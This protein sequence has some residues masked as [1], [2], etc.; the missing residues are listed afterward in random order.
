MCCFSKQLWFCACAV[1]Y[2]W[3]CLLERVPRCYWRVVCIYVDLMSAWKLLLYYHSSFSSI[4][5]SIV[6]R[7]ISLSISHPSIS[8]PSILE[9]CR[10]R[11]ACAM[12]F[13][14]AHNMF[15]HSL[16]VYYIVVVVVYRLHSVSLYIYLLTLFSFCVSVFIVCSG[17]SNWI[18]VWYGCAHIGNNMLN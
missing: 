5:P 11:C 6:L 10:W 8:L 13:S 4:L 3:F 12:C 9:I 18:S 7:H 15:T 14:H 1:K 17:F 2:F 16:H